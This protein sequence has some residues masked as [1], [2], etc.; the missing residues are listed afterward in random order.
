[1]S[2]IANERADYD[3][4]WKQAIEEFLEAFLAFFFPRVWALVD[5]SRPPQSLETELQQVFPTSEAGR[6][7][8]DKLFQA[9]RADGAEVWI[10]IHL[11][12]QSQE[13]RAFAQ[14]MFAYYYRL[15]DR[16]QRGVVSL[17]VL[18]D[19]N[20]GWR[21]QVYATELG[22]C[23][24]RFAFPTVKLLDCDDAALSASDN[25]FAVVTA[26][27][28]RA[29]RTTGRA[30]E[31]QQVKVQLVRDLFGRG[32]SRGEIVR[33]LRAIDGL[34]A[35][36]AALQAGF[37]T[38]LRA[39]QEEMQMPV[40]M[41][42]EV[43]A[44]EQGREEG[45]AS[46]VEAILE[47]VA[48]RFEA[49][50]LALADEERD[51]WRDRLRAIADLATL[52]QFHRQAL[53]AAT[54]ADFAA[55]LPL[56]EQPESPQADRPRVARASGVRKHGEGGIRTHGLFRSSDFKSDAIDHSA[57]SPSGY[58]GSPIRRLQRSRVAQ[59]CCDSS[60]RSAFNTHST[61]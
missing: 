7:Y 39:I 2:E 38:E 40:L 55:V 52:Q 5:W 19:E 25:P 20:P 34:L 58:R 17:A 54:L 37:E 50:W 10:L 13:D 44:L 35:L 28:L 33:L 4:T 49:D 59:G 6:R 14:R 61:R 42:L 9:W 24:L 29:K 3:G 41:E 8:A 15:L 57:T 12:V 30:A 1:M 21:P 31:R 47:I 46:L 60:G 27:H 11:E 53:L 26:A 51:R 45:R 48:V 32:Y 36:P 56:T 18:G 43:R 22:G 16:Y 23:E